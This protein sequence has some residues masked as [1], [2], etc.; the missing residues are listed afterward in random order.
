[1]NRVDSS[2]AYVAQQP[3]PSAG[4]VIDQLCTLL[5]CK[6]GEVMQVVSELKERGDYWLFS[7]CELRNYLG[8]VEEAISEPD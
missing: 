1:M 8:D 2:V 7:W 4:P 5:R 6:P 3:G